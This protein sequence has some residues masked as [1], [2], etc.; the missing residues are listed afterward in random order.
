MGGVA[1]LVVISAGVTCLPHMVDIPSY[2]AELTKKDSA[3]GAV[4]NTSAA[5]IGGRGRGS[6]W[7]NMEDK[8]KQ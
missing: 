4:Q 2:R 8:T 3:A 6:M 1:L 7:K 5:S